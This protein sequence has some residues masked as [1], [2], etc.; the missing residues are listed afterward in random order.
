ML[1]DSDQPMP[2]TK[3]AL[4]L[5]IAFILIASI[6]LGS[7]TLGQ[8]NDDL[9]TDE[10]T[11]TNHEDATA[12]SLTSATDFNIR[13]GAAQMDFA[14]DLDNAWRDCAPRANNPNFAGEWTIDNFPV[15][16]NPVDEEPR[17]TGLLTMQGR[18][19]N[20]DTGTADNDANERPTDVTIRPMPTDFDFNEMGEDCASFG[21]GMGMGFGFGSGMGELV[22]QMCSL[23]IEDAFISGLGEGVELH[24]DGTMTIT[25]IDGD[26][27]VVEELS[28]AAVEELSGGLDTLV[29]SCNMMMM[30]MMN[31]MGQGMPGMGQ[32]MPGMNQ[33][34]FGDGNNGRDCEHMNNPNFNDEWPV[35]EEPRVTG[36]QTM[37]VRPSN[38]NTENADHDANERRAGE[39]NPCMDWE[40]DWDGDWGDFDHEWRENEL[41]EITQDICEERGGIWT[42][43]PDRGEGYHYCDWAEEDSDLSDEN[44]SNE[45]D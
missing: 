31:G 18:P 10:N 29:D 15:D 24:E 30:L 32:G 37:Q 8:A 34:G 23:F 26:A 9:R 45:T 6:V 22:S 38:T 14:V 28:A 5:G 7:G 42:E 11:D 1:E 33:G 19:G 3:N 27:I 40:F 44:D 43:A 39:R 36:L 35:D 2:Q 17:A 21:Q 20:S 12:D 16:T 4:A 41:N 25:T 13:D